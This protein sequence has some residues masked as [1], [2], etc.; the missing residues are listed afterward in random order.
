MTEGKDEVEADLQ[1]RKTAMINDKASTWVA[2][3]TH[4]DED[5]KGDIPPYGRHGVYEVRGGKTLGRGIIGVWRTATV[6]RHEGVD[7]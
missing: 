4:D 7:P 1:K 5:H 6:A 3:G 2:D